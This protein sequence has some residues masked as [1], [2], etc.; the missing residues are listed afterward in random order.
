MDLNSLLEFEDVSLN[1][2]PTSDN[3]MSHPI[4]KNINLNVGEGDQI[5]V[6]GRNGSGKTS[7]L[8]LMVGTYSAS[9]GAIRRNASI[10][11]F[12]DL[13]AGMNNALTGEENLILKFRLAGLNKPEAFSKARQCLEF[14]E[15]GEH[16]GKALGR[17]SSGMK[18]R[19]AFSALLQSPAEVLILDEWLSVGDSDFKIKAESELKR[20]IGES[21]A[22]I[23]ATHSEKLV[24]S[25]CNRL[26]ILESGRVTKD[27]RI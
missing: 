7:L 22:L 8:R 1:S 9:S 20:I 6:M 4:L 13:S 21:K 24:E 26:L 19:L 10:T 27:G 2:S 11:S 16:A 15:L 5:A 3:R 14:A 18:M 23:I 25:L 12:L 17:Y